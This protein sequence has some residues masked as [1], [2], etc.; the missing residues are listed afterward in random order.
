VVVWY[1]FP[2]LVRLDHEK[3]GNPAC[4]Q[5]QMIVKQNMTLGRAPKNSVARSCSKKDEITG[6][7]KKC[8]KNGSF[9]I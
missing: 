4:R 1:I 5:G 6:G 3:S 9:E 2:I 7:G 8:G